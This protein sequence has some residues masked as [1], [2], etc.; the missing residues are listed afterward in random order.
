MALTASYVAAS[1]VFAFFAY[2]L[3]TPSS[4]RGTHLTTTIKKS[5]D[6]IVIG[7]GSTGCVVASRL[8]EDKDVSVLMLEAGPDDR[9]D[10]IV[11]TPG[12]S[13]HMM[14]SKYDWEFYTEP[15][16]HGLEG[17]NERRAYWPRGRVLGGTSNLYSMVYIRGHKLDYDK[18][19]NS[20]AEGWSYDEVLPFFLMS[21][22]MQDSALKKSKY[23]NTG[24]PMKVS[25]HN[26]MPLTNILIK[27]GQEIGLK[28][29]DPNGEAM[30][31]LSLT[32]STSYKGERY[33]SSRG[34]IHPIIS[35][36]NLHVRLD[37]HVTKIIF[38]GKKAVGV[39]L[40][41]NGRKERVMANK[42][43]I[44]SGGAVSSPQI[45]MLSG[46]G[47]KKH[48]KEFGIPVVADLPVGLNLQD[49]LFYEFPIAVNQT[50]SATQAVQESLWTKMQL[51]LFGTGVLSS[52]HYVEVQVFD[53]T[54]EKSRQQNWPDLQIM[55]H[56]TPWTVEALR[57]F[58][59]NKDV[60]EESA[61]RMTH[62]DMFACEASLLRPESRGTVKLRSSDPFD[63]PV[64]DPNYLERQED[65]DLLVRGIKYCEKFLD[66]PTMRS[67]G[68]APGDKPSRFCKKH[69]YD[70]TPYWECMVR[71]KI[72]T[73]YHPSGTCKMGAVGDPTAV[74]DPQLRVQ[75][76][77]GLRVAD[78]SIMP[79]IPSGNTHAPCV[80]VGE[81]AAHMIKQAWKK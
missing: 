44:L 45:L 10:P 52:S 49:H 58:G 78:A 33:S 43:I 9:G 51:K 67:I 30:E 25:V 22:D 72:H 60:L 77:T 62:T 39:E 31:G 75:G 38:E 36:E 16:K 81:K 4:E 61:Y 3:W 32:Q 79:F 56:Q 5:Y 35:R 50:V 24:G 80:M 63:P 1:V 14:H 8:S 18:W 34:Y 42:E 64:I 13:H 2:H 46:V 47:P 48:L 57:L 76:I 66:P 29:N 68:A 19:A 28:L 40:I 11:S 59:Y 37:S 26:T 69:Q 6:Y 7:A 55:F 27:A 53:S 17:Y 12:W 21:E 70:S 41:Y 74:V 54:D 15:Q 65:V 23:H 20:G 73:I 71:R